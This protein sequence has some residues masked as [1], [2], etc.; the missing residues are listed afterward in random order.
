MITSRF[1]STA[2]PTHW[3]QSV[4]ILISEFFLSTTTAR[5]IIA[6]LSASAWMFFSSFIF[7]GMAMMFLSSFFLFV[8]KPSVFYR[9]DAIDES[10]KQEKRKSKKRIK[11]K[12]DK[13]KRSGRA[14]LLHGRRNES[15][16]TRQSGQKAHV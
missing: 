5:L 6:D 12:I 7:Y 4:D 9:T 11:N 3:L 2:L 16:F 8:R 13:K 14:G 10:N 1:R 15:Y